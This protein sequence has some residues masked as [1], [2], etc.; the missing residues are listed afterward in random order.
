[1]KQWQ[2]KHSMFTSCDNGSVC[3]DK[4]KASQGPAEETG[5]QTSIFMLASPFCALPDSALQ[6]LMNFFSDP[7]TRGIQVPAW[8]G[9]VVCPG[10]D[11]NG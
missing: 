3:Q 4:A 8:K 7:H 10:W 9:A 2:C 5:F 6:A 11:T 1:M